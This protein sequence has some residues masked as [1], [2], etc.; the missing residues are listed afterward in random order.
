MIPEKLGDSCS[1]GVFLLPLKDNMDKNISETE[2]NALVSEVLGYTEKFNG[3]I[4][5]IKNMF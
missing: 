3:D 2:K 4:D 5:T 1:V